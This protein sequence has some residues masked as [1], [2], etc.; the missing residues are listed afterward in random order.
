MLE[1]WPSL[2]TGAQSLVTKLQVCNL[3]GWSDL[4]FQ[5]D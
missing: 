4:S 1:G 2:V 3:L 5:V